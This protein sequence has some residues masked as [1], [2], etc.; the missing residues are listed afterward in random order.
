MDDTEAKHNLWI[1]MNIF[2]DYLKYTIS[3]RFVLIIQ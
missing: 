3:F 1:W 2:E